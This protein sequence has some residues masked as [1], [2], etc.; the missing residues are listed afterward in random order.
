MRGTTAFRPGQSHLNKVMVEIEYA[1]SGSPSEVVKKL[2][3]PVILSER[4]ITAFSF[5]GK[6]GDASVRS[7]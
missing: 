5:Q 7:A 6:Y 2:S 3:G 1:V 4:R